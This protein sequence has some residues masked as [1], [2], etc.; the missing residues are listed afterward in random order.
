[1][2][3]EF[4]NNST[5]GALARAVA[6]IKGGG[7]VAF[8]TDTVY[9]LAASIKFPAAVSRIFDIKGRET[10][11][12]LP[13]LVADTIQMRQVAEMTPL[14]D[15]LVRR[16]MPG[17]LTV[18][19]KKTSEVPDIVTGDRDTVAV[20]IPGHTL[21]LYLIKACGAP[22][23]GTSANLSGHGSVCTAG[24]V[25]AQIGHLVDFVLDGGSC[26]GGKEST[27][28][29]LTSDPPAIVREGAVEREEL[30]NFYK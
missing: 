13:V 4:S 28:I 16:F 1:M 27:I 8:P 30:E 7:V 23:T 14:A 3:A 19:L 25:S 24:E 15:R 2:T 6:I 26:P 18:I 20:R 5:P 22:L 21:P 17:G 11:K 10:T 29:D 12:A 9:C